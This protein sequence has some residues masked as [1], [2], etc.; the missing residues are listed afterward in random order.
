MTTHL[1]NRVNLNRY[2]KNKNLIFDELK[3]LQNKR[4]I[5]PIFWTIGI[6]LF[7]IILPKYSTI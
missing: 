1:N 3:V 7:R 2:K 4:I 6:H 5:W